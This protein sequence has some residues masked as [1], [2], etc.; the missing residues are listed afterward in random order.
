MTREQLTNEI[1]RMLTTELSQEHYACEDQWH[2][3]PKVP[4]GGPWDHD[5]NPADDFCTCGAD[6][7]NAKIAQVAILVAGLI[8]RSLYKDAAPK[9][10][11]P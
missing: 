5:G 11:T 3:C 9:Q 1:E 8:P 4:G 7:H 2:S 10:E 6:I